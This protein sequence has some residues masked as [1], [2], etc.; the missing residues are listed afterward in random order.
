[1]AVTRAFYR[2]G[3]RKAG[4]VGLGRDGAGGRRLGVLHGLIGGVGRWLWRLGLG[5]R[6]GAEVEFGELNG[7]Y[8]P[9]LVADDA[10]GVQATLDPECDALVDGLAVRRGA[11][12]IG[13][14]EHRHL[15]QAVSNPQ[16]RDVID[17]N[18][19]GVFGG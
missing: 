18:R 1:M 11:E 14:A 10:P 17:G 16:L 3:A 19:V 9:D 13:G 8:L 6:A 15:G 12:L 7:P 2:G 5:L 4:L